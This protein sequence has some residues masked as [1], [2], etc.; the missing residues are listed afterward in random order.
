MA[1]VEAFK[2]EG[3]AGEKKLRGFISV[4]GSKNEALPLFASVLLFSGDVSFVNVPKISDMEKIT[5][6]LQNAGVTVTR[7][8]DVARMQIGDIASSVID[9]KTAGLFRAS[10]I[11]TGS[12]LARTG[13]V[14][15]PPPGGCVIGKRPI[16][17]FLSGY[18]KMG[19]TVAVSD[20]GEQFHITAPEGGLRGAEILFRIPSVTATETLLMAAVLA[21]GDS[22][23]YNAA[24]EPE[25]VGLAEF[26]KKS[27]AHIEG[28]GTPTLHIKGTGGV[29]LTYSGTEPHRII[30]DR[31]EAGS[32]AILGALCA[33]ELTITNCA[34]E[35]LRLPLAM[36]EDCGVPIEVTKDT[37]HIRNNT[38]ANT[39]LKP[40]SIRTHEY[41]GFPTDM[42]APFG[43]LATQATGESIVEEFIFEGRLGY[44][45]DIARMGAQIVLAHPH[46]AIIQGPTKLTGRE[47]Y[48]PDLRAGLA[49]VIAA[50]VGK[51]ISH[52][53]N[54]HY[55]DRGYENLEEKLR[56]IGV[57]IE[58]VEV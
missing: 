10:I 13:T 39:E 5:S 20:D 33:H 53:H 12:I 46:K 8:L 55:I 36:L 22:T 19:A 2:I 21:H 35:D 52:I 42:Q 1:S 50:C 43:I 4:S 51:G 6:L 16:D 40:C 57:A 9:K 31:I 27:G 54:I 44:L 48:S 3:L 24:M 32:F 37:I 28:I 15:F 56:N 26:L 38:Q 49:Y 7:D 29:P 58:R 47:L 45:E 18:E 14:T 25:I 41:P 11:L 23:L 34:P 30:P 17:I